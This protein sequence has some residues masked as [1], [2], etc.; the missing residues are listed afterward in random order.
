MRARIILAALPVLALAACG[1]PAP[2]SSPEPVRPSA[3]RIAAPALPPAPDW[4]DWPRTPGTWTYAR[5]SRGS[6]ALFGTAGDD[7]LLSLRCD[8]A[9]RRLYLSR[10][11]SAVTPLTIRTSSATRTLGVQPTGGTPA[12]VAVVLSPGDPLLD[13]IGFSR[14]RFAV[15]QAGAAPLAVPAWPEIERVTED[16]RG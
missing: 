15:E 8:L 11:G 3:P 1:T 4:R 12:Y 10:R 13:A 14:G 5:D 7:A 2:R 9:A 16:C 6:L